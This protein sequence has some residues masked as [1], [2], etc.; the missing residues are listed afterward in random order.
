MGTFCV[1]FLAAW[2]AASLLVKSRSTWAFTRAA[3]A[4]FVA[5]GSPFV[6]RMSNVTSRPS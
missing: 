2:V 6:K 1:A 4:V 3:A 5:D